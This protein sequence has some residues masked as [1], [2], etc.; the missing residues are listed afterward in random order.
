MMTGK[1]LIAIGGQLFGW[2]NPVGWRFSAAVAGTV[3]VFLV[4]RLA[5]NLFRSPTVDALA[6]LFLATD[7]ID[8]V[9]SRTS[10]LDVFLSTFVLGAFL[11]VV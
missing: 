1:W 2:D 10:L 8:L 3:G 5:W 11:A 4:C 6:G 9:L 7:G